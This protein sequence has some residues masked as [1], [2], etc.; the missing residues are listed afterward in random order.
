[1]KQ[2]YVEKEQ[3]GV[4]LLENST[5]SF[6]ISFRKVNMLHSEEQLVLKDVRHCQFPLHKDN[7]I[8]IIHIHHTVKNLSSYLT[9][10]GKIWLMVSIL[11]H[12]KWLLPNQK[13]YTEFTKCLVLLISE[14]KQVKL[15]KKL[16]K[17]TTFLVFYCNDFQIPGKSRRRVN[18]SCPSIST[19][20][21]TEVF[22]YN[23]S[24]TTVIAAYQGHGCWYQW[25]E[26]H[27]YPEHGPFPFHHA[28]R[29]KKYK[30]KLF[31]SILQNNNIIILFN[32]RKSWSRKHRGHT[33]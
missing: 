30:K 28:P 22:I 29:E 19:N 24:T 21:S 7:H 31:S 3:Y 27:L 16:D 4:R 18:I 12:L 23:W 17:T 14:E 8:Y 26:L 13:S 6:I 33:Q 2:M 9:L 10:L 32:K 1:M 20:R 15:E 5:S 25:A 11:E